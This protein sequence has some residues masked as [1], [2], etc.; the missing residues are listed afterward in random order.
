MSKETTKT[1]DLEMFPYMQ[2]KKRGIENKKELIDLLNKRKELI[3][4]GWETLSAYDQ[5]ERKI[6]LNKTEVELANSHK[7]IHDLQIAFD[8]RIGQL[9][10]LLEEIEAKWDFIVTQATKLSAKNKDLADYMLETDTSN[11]E[12]NAEEKLSY[13]IK[14]RQFVNPSKSAMK[15]VPKEPVN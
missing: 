7:Q 3:Q 14:L 8:E 5:N 13:Y 6:L 2:G 15:I 1:L 4:T 11:F 10:E 12:N 9:I